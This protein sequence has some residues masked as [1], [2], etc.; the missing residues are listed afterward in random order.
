MRSATASTNSLNSA[1]AP[2]SFRNLLIAL[3]IIGFL[4]VLISFSGRM[5]GG[6]VYLE[7]W[8]RVKK[9]WADDNAL[10]RQ[11]GYE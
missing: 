3:M 4:S 9:G 5:F 11:Y 2:E 1:E 10:L 8:V 6:K 7:L